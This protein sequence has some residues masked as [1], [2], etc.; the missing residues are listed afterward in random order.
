MVVGEEE[1]DIVVPFAIIENVPIYPGCESAQGN[2]ERKACFQKMIQAHIVKEFN[3]P[4][5]FFGSKIKLLL[6]I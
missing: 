2:D 4:H 3:Y 6:I 5:L 1:E